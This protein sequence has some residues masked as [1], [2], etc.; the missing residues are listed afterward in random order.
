MFAVVIGPE[1]R[2]LL[3]RYGRRLTRR[4]HGPEAA[5]LARRGARAVTPADYLRR[6][7]RP[8]AGSPSPAAPPLLTAWAAL[9]L[10][11]AGRRPSERSSSSVTRRLQ[12]TTDLALAAL[13]EGELGRDPSAAARA[14]P[15][16]RPRQRGRLVRSSRS[17]RAAGRLRAGSSRTCSDASGE[18]AAFRGSAAGADSND[19]AAAIQ[20]LRAAASRGRRSS[21][22]SRTSRAPEP[23]RRLPARRRSG[24]DAQSTRWAIQ[25]YLAAGVKPPA[26]AFR[27][28]ASLRRPD[29]SYRYSALRD[30]PVGD[31]AG[32]PAL[33][34]KPF[35]LR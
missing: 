5:A 6:A 33:G 13:A 25:A 7:S 21:A 24:P 32:L 16:D 26:A 28:L 27:F 30:T 4:W 35:P 1:L 11:A 19:T 9:G 8:T 22:R 29:G 18:T 34:R 20:A 14:A 17:G 10:K 23:R 31:R 3:E 2:R 12:E 15:A